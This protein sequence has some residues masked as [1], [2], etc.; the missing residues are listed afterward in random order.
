MKCDLLLNRRPELKGGQGQ[1][2]KCVH[3]QAR[4]Q[5]LILFVYI[6]YP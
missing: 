6:V 3:L 5:E 1:A 4:A 2:R